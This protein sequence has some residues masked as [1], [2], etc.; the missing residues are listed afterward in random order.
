MTDSLAILSQGDDGPGQGLSY[1][2]KHSLTQETVYGSLLLKRRREIHRWVAECVERLYAENLDDSAAVLA[3]HFCEAGNDPKTIEYAVRAGDAAMRIYANAEAVAEYS[4]A[5][6][7]AGRGGHP[8]P[9]LLQDVYLKRGRAIELQS[10][11]DAAARNYDEMKEAAAVSGD[12][13]FELAALIAQA[14]IRS[15]PGSARDPEQAQMLAEQALDLAREVGDRKAEAKILWTLLLVSVYAGGDAVKAR[16]Y[17]EQSLAIAREFNLRE[18]MAYTLHDLFVAYS[19]L[20]EME[21]ARTVRIEA[22]NIFRELDNRPMLAESLSGQALLDF[23][24]GNPEPAIPRAQEALQIS[25]TIGNLGGQGFSGY[26]LAAV[27]SEQGQFVEALKSLDEAIPITDSGGLEGNGLSPYAMIGLTHAYLG[28]HMT[29]RAFLRKTFDRQSTKLPMQKMWLYALLARIELAAGD[30]QAADAAFADGKV[31]ASLETF[32]K[33]FPASAQHFYF[34]SCELALAHEHYGR[35]LE[36]IGALREHLAQIKVKAFLPE[37][38]FLEGRALLGMGDT[39]AALAAWGAGL[40]EA[41]TQTSRR[42][43]W[44]ILLAMSRA[45]SASGNSV[46]AERLRAEACSIVEYIADH[47]PPNLR[48]SFL[49]L[50]D[51]IAALKQ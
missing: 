6:Q 29:A 5:L 32:T 20:G 41:H 26:V 44:Q 18:Q 25:R 36:L 50:P 23:L 3:Q 39:P 19:Y 49:K 12:R 7:A 10:Q 30:L 11:F 34:S 17:G 28:D 15:I 4:L 43:W 1:L 37:A 2:F 8:E 42:I 14:N 48:T 9:T 45:Q 47:C 31:V 24:T 21:K 13:A 38:H 40:T 51:V 16:E 22:S 27:Y 33:M 46:E 35:A